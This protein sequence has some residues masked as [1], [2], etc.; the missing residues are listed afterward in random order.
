MPRRRPLVSDMGRAFD[1]T[2]SYASLLVVLA[3]ALSLAAGMNL[4]L[5]NYSKTPH[6]PD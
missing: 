3:L 6:T 2:G 5:P 4:L 1:S